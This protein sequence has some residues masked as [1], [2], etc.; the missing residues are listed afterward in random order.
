MYHTPNFWFKT[1]T[2][3]QYTL[4][5]HLYPLWGHTTYQ[6]LTEVQGGFPNR[7]FP[8][9]ERRP[10][11]QPA[12]SATPLETAKLVKGCKSCLAVFYRGLVGLKNAKHSRGSKIQ[13]YKF[14]GAKLT[15]NQ[16][17]GTEK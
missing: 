17:K 2:W 13:K 3:T 14:L 11:E 10:T 6:D 15:E 4:E 7:A 9:P 1:K 8:N 16:E 12:Q 5:S